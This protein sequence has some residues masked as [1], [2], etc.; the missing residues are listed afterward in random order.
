MVYE[1]VKFRS[2]YFSYLYRMTV[3]Q[4]NFLHF[5]YYSFQLNFLHTLQQLAKKLILS[6]Y[7]KLWKNSSR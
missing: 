2:L 4:N 7:L 3:A 1:S 6:V 5:L